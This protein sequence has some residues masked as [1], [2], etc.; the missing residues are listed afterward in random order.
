MH[1]VASETKTMLAS[2]LPQQSPRPSNSAPAFP[3]ASL[4]GD[5][6]P[7]VA[8]GSP[9]ERPAQHD[10]GP[11]T[12]STQSSELPAKAKSAKPPNVTASEKIKAGN[13]A[14]SAGKAPSQTEVPAGVTKA[15]GDPAR[16]HD[17]GKTID[18]NADALPG[19]AGTP[20]PATP[21][22]AIANPV[23]VAL[24]PVGAAAAAIAQAE[25]QQGPATAG[26]DGMP[27]LPVS[28]ASRIGKVKSG[29]AIV[30]QPEKLGGRPNAQ[31]GKSVDLLR[32]S[33]NPH[34]PG[35]DIG[36]VAPAD[37]KA[38]AHRLADPPVPAVNGGVAAA[39][40]TAGGEQK[41]TLSAPAIAQSG[42][43]KS[44]P[45]PAPTWQADD[46]AKTQYGGPQTAASGNG[47]P[48][49]DEM[50]KLIGADLDGATQRPGATN[51]QTGPV[52]AAGVAAAKSARS[53]IAKLAIT[54]DEATVK[55][56]SA[57]QGADANAPA[58]ESTNDNLDASPVSD[59]KPQ[60]TDDTGKPIVTGATAPSRHT[61]ADVLAS[62]PPQSGDAAAKAA[63][64]NQ[65]LISVTTPNHAGTS[66]TQSIPQA[67][68]QSAMPQAVPLA[69]VA[70]EIA[71]R[72]LA[73]KNR[74]DIR[75]DPPELGRIDVRLDVDRDGR[76]T[77]HLIA[78]RPDTLNLLR[79]DSAGLERALQDAG[80]KTSDNGLQFSLRDQSMGRDQAQMP[81]AGASQLVVDDDAHTA[82]AVPPRYSRIAGMGAGIDIRV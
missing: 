9:V 77:S 71:S 27:T 33:R 20:A 81:A 36:E 68:P 22:A 57:D 55:S 72:A 37:D 1:Q 61:S 23:A 78:D 63:T 82:A 73:G 53:N 64:G 50:I 60:T 5:P 70:I 42:E 6:A 3:F 80:L 67:L 18:I 30:S 52:V 75:L 28:G 49:R 16:S 8:D 65:P 47:D 35:K 7:A 31:A 10:N 39:K 40:A 41:P 74:F 54:G 24:D 44:E 79:Q 32:N 51:R 26:D 29:P 34:V 58:A 14:Q 62:P 2:H 11:R 19:G 66:A 46:A 15:K 43:G 59:R 17:E 25:P 45:A 12:E 38:I 69:G 21:T 56:A 4:L 48:V 13:S 76:V